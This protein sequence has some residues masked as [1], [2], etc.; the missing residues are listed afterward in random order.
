MLKKMTK[1]I[2]ATL[3]FPLKLVRFLK[4]VKAEP[5]I[6]VTRSHNVVMKKFSLDDYIK[7]KEDECTIQEL[8]A[9]Q[10]GLAVTGDKDGAL[11][12]PTFD[13]TLPSSTEQEWIAKCTSNKKQ[14]TAQI[15]FKDAELKSLLENLLNNYEEYSLEERISFFLLQ[16]QKEINNKFRGFFKATNTEQSYQEQIR[17]LVEQINQE[18]AEQNDLIRNTYHHIRPKKRLTDY[19]GLYFILLILITMGE[20]PLNITALQYLGEFSNTFVLTLSGFFA[21]IMGF[22]AHLAGH[23]FFKKHK[24]EWISAVGLGLAVCLI[25][26]VL[27]SHLEGSAIMSFMNV[28]VFFFGCFISYYR[29]RNLA[30][31][32]SVRQKKR[33]QRQKVRKQALIDRVM[34]EYRAEADKEVREQ[35]DNLRTFIDSGSAALATIEAYK[36]NLKNRID[37]IHEEGLAIYRNANTVSRRKAGHKPIKLW[38]QA[39]AGTRVSNNSQSATSTFYNFS[40]VVVGLIWLLGLV[41][42]GTPEPNE[43]IILFDVTDPVAINNLEKEKVAPYLLEEVLDLPDDALLSEGLH[44]TVSSIG[45]ISIQYRN[46]AK[47]EVGGS[48]LSRTERTRKDDVQAFKEEINIHIDHI[49]KPNKELGQ[50]VLMH[51][52]CEHLNTLAS[53]KAPK[54]AILIFSDMLHNT[55]EVSFY[56]YRNNPT[57]LLEHYE[58]LAA[59]M[60]KICPLPAL[61]NITLTIIYLPSE[62]TDRLFQASKTFWSKYLTDYGAEVFFSPNL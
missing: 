10:K 51:N 36:L 20:F 37:A 43:A 7:R 49:A 6:K 1:V 17:D 39:D 35:L 11:G 61:N 58:T 29:A 33:L 59:K 28:L 27:R 47:L 40:Q 4:K 9:T 31:W 48:F 41:G 8:I 26:S 45:S 18:D 50:T 44:V 13:T 42:C 5:E 57:Q 62:K 2:R 30:F 16:R 60:D 24:G 34:L 15:D 22:S 12:L 23:A 46:M 19:T 55:P 56:N 38:E 54:K 53:S 52:L 3:M 21:L 14:I 32:S 25:V